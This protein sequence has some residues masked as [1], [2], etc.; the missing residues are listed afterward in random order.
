MVT[1]A[2]GFLRHWGNNFPV[3]APLFGISH[4]W[5]RTKIS[6]IDVHRE[7]TVLK[8]RCAVE[9]YVVA[10]T[11]RGTNSHFYSLIRRAQAV[12]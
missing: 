10:E 6:A 4:L 7:R 3:L 1:N 9:K 5:L 8:E 11:I 2:G 12:V